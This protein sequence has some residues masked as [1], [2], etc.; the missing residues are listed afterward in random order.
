MSHVF[1]KTYSCH[2][3]EEL[4]VSEVSVVTHERIHTGIIKFECKICDFKAN[5]YVEME[6][7]KKVNFTLSQNELYN[8]MNM[9]TCAP[10]ARKSLPNGPK[11]KIIR[12][13]STEDISRAK[14]VPVSGQISFQKSG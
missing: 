8:R 14:V 9:V 1:S 2:F 11:S 4:F 7:H 13:A 10:S 12:F 6:E 5:R 3:C